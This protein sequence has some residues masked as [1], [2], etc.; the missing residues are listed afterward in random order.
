MVVLRDRLDKRPHVSAHAALVAE[1]VYDRLVDH[2]EDCAAGCYPWRHA[3]WRQDGLC[4]EGAALVD[5]YAAAVLAALG[6]RLDA[7]AALAVR[8]GYPG[9]VPRPVVLAGER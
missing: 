3:P 4:P 6:S 2:I 9:E 7:G 8:L 5:D 1:A